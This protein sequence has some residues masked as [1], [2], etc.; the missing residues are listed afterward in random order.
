MQRSAEANIRSAVFPGI[1]QRQ[2]V[3]I[4]FRG[5]GVSATGVEIVGCID[6]VH[7]LRRVHGRRCVY[8][9]ANVVERRTEVGPGLERGPEGSR[10]L[11]TA[12]RIA[13]QYAQVVVRGGSSIGRPSCAFMK[14]RRAAL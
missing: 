5:L 2:S 12:L 9:P 11:G 4:V 14:T 6:E 10:G 7:E 13:Q 8:C 3:A 1:A